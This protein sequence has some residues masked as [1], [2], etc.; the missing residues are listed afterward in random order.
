MARPLHKLLAKLGLAADEAASG[1]F[2]GIMDAGAGNDFV[3]GGSG[4]DY[5]IGG[6]GDDRLYGRAGNDLLAG[7]E[8]NDT[9]SGDQGTDT[10]DGGNGTDTADFSGSS[11]PVVVNLANGTLTGTADLLISIENFAG[12]SFDDRLSGD[13]N[14]NVFFGGAGDDVLVGHAGGDTLDGGQ[15]NDL[16]RGGPGDDLLSG[17]QGNDA[18]IGGSGEDSFVYG[19]TSL[20]VG[21]VAAGER[22]SILAK[23]G[24][25]ISMAGLMDELEVGGVA[26]NALS[27]DTAIGNTL[28]AD[29]NIAFVNGSLLIDIDGDGSFSATQDFQIA[30]TGVTAVAYDAGGDVFQLS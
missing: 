11:E 25:R 17:G 23:A 10:L 28:D 15:G 27:A 16:I 6:E 14:G 18:I 30:L 24:D 26:L 20:G 8:G 22:D 19:A 21:D 2:D 7:G 29:T 3:I 12:S 13:A 4:N 1:S 5:L 9:L